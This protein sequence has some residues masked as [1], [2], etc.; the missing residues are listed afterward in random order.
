ML[1]R[2]FEAVFGTSSERWLKRYELPLAR[3][4]ALEAEVKAL[5]D[6]A[7]PQKT[8]ELR[9]R[10]ASALQDVPPGS[11]DEEKAAFTAAEKAALDELLPEAFALVREASRRAIGLRHYDV[12]K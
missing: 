3:I 2:L 7:F 10:L 11:T 9:Q 1:Q 4:N 8:L 6:E 12:R 5:P